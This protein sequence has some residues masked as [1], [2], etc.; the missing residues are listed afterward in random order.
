MEEL[1]AT[2]EAQGL[3][4][5]D[6]DIAAVREQKIASFRAAVTAATGLSEAQIPQIGQGDFVGP[7]QPLQGAIRQIE[8]HAATAEMAPL[9]YEQQRQL[10][11][12]A[13]RTS[14]AYLAG[15]PIDPRTV[16]WN[17][18]AAQAAGALSPRQIHAIRTEAQLRQLVAM[19]HEFNAQP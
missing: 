14:P 3:T 4:M 11:L 8:I 13:A 6:P 12:I 15:G 1:R 5:N 10:A 17:A 2:A 19:V 16:D 7:L 18:V 9:T